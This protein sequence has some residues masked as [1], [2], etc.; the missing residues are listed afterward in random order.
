[1]TVICADAMGENSREYAL[2]ALLPEAFTGA[3]LPKND[4]N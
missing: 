4:S 2:S 1:M 3:S